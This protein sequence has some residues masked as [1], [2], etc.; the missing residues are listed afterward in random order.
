MHGQIKVVFQMKECPLDQVKVNDNIAL[1]LLDEGE[2]VFG[3][4]AGLVM[5]HETR[6][7]F[8]QLVDKFGELLEISTRRPRIL[9]RISTKPPGNP[10]RKD[11]Q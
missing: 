11:S 2:A 1:Q 8:I 6:E 9:Y 7:W 10:T 4:F 3:Q 5:E